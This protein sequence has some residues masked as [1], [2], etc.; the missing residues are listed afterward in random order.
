MLCC[1]VL[2]E[3]VCRVRNSLRS[4]DPFPFIS[5]FCRGKGG[6]LKLNYRNFPPCACVSRKVVCG[7]ETRLGRHLPV[8]CVCVCVCV[9]TCFVV[10]L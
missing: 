5:D 2:C 4:S 6:R 8:V 3:K 10:Q 9:F 1:V 7:P